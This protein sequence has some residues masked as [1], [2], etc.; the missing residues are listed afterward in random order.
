MEYSRKKTIF[1]PGKPSEPLVATGPH[2][3]WKKEGSSRKF[4]IKNCSKV[5]FEVRDRIF[6]LSW[7]KTAFFSITRQIS[8]YFRGFSFL[9]YYHEISHQKCTTKLPC[10]M[11]EVELV[12][13]PCRVDRGS[14]IENFL[15]VS[16]KLGQIIF[17]GS[18]CI[19]GLSCGVKST[20]SPFLP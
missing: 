12:F 14:K 10:S 5:I 20:F 19:L 7:L 11:K 15:K 13:H 1:F 16:W 2:L 9:R 6:S 3:A 8:K 18:N 4:L 17:L